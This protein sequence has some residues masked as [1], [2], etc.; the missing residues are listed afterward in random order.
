MFRLLTS[1][2]KAYTSRLFCDARANVKQCVNVGLRLSMELFM[3][4]L[5]IDLTD[6]QHQRMDLMAR[7]TGRLNA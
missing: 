2:N 1:I 5:T 7:L 4:H 6:Q 3:S